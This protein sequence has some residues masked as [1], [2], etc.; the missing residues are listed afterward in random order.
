MSEIREARYMSFGGADVID[1]VRQEPRQLGP[2]DAAVDMM[3]S[4]INP[5]DVKRRSGGQGAFVPTGGIL[6]HTDGAGI[7]HSVGNNVHGLT[8]GQRV[9]VWG[10]GQEIGT[11]ADRAIIPADRI[12]PLPDSASFELGASLGIPAVT[13]ALCLS[14]YG[15]L[16]VDP[17]G[18]PFDGKYVL[19]RG[20]GAVAHFAIQLAKHMGAYVAVSASERKL[21]SAKTAGADFAVDR[22]SMSAH[23]ELG[24]FSLAGY[25]LIVDVSPAVNM[26]SNIELAAP[27]STIALYGREGGDSADVEFRELQAKNITIRSIRTVDLP[28]AELAVGAH[29]AAQAIESLGVGKEHGFPLSIFSLDRIGEAHAMVESGPFHGKALIDLSRRQ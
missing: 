17:A 20:A 4:G 27:R 9:W 25:D 7:I 1:L 5:L 10:V 15:D 19:V 13:A 23:R 29:M 12:L 8:P 18:R 11:A 22:N 3:M 21:P 16:P 6:P 24:E 26:E 28:T 14:R 2:D